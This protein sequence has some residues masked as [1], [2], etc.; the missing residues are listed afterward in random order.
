MILDDNSSSS[1]LSSVSSS[2]S[3][4]DSYGELIASHNPD[5]YLPLAE[6]TAPGSP[7][8]TPDAMGNYNG[9]YSNNGSAI[10]GVSFGDL[11]PG[12]E[13]YAPELST[14]NVTCDTTNSWTTFTVEMWLTLDST[15]TT[16]TA[17]YLTRPGYEASEYSH[18]IYFQS[19]VGL[20][21]YLYNGAARDISSGIIPTVGTRCHVVITAANNDTMKIYV[22]G[23]L[24]A[25]SATLTADPWTPGYRWIIGGFQQWA[26]QVAHFAAYR[27]VLSADKIAAH[28][29]AGVA[30]ALDERSSDSSNSSSSDSSNSSSSSSS[31][32]EGLPTHMLDYSPSVWW[33][34]DEAY[35]DDGTT[36]A[37]NTQAI[38]YWRDISG[39]GRHVTQTSSTKKP[40]FT[41]SAINGFGALSFNAAAHHVLSRASE[42][43]M[44]HLGSGTNNTMIFVIKPVNAQANAIVSIWTTNFRLSC[45]VPWSTTLY[46]DVV[47][48]TGGRHSGAS[49]TG[50]LNNW[51]IVVL[52]RNGAN[53]T[54]RV[55]GKVI[56]TN[57]TNASGTATSQTG[58]WY[59]GAY[60]NTGGASFNGLM[61]EICNIPGALSDADVEDI[62]D[63]LADKYG[64]LAQ[65]DSSNSSSSSSSKSS[66]SS[67]SSYSSN[68]SSYSSPSSGGA[69]NES[70]SSQSS[71]PHN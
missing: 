16:M 1:S 28:Y 8:T 29:A 23:E 42:D 52:R 15:A 50:F 20:R 58:P 66:K 14:G 63:Y 68:S 26:G 54:I 19:G 18:R 56:G 65:S 39:N 59:V 70:S 32:S 27:S 60:D 21:A 64:L 34:G 12:T 46:Y 6:S 71:G 3:S 36:R 25:Q 4:A 53:M 67:M 57:K 24:K 5:V 51:H 44:N 9:T 35:T 40:T 31:S 49:P 38:Q 7:F 13:W 37:T 17:V 41:A 45:H 33:V 43:I 10:A 69:V 55:D 30:D 47:N 2:S 48:A 11:M 61:A 22:N 62:E